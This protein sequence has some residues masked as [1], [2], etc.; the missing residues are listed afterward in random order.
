M[1]RIDN[2]NLIKIGI[3]VDDIE[4]AASRYA[5]L[6]G[7]PTPSFSIPDPNST[8]THTPESYTWYRGDYVPARTKFA[9]IQMGPVTV[10]LLEPYDEASPWNEFRQKHGQG[11]HFITVT[12]N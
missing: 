8:V 5:Q 11:V 6:F 2:S 7:L 4:A 1:D 12:V 9:N 10:E 3:V